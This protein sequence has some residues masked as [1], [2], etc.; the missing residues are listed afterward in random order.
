MIRLISN[1]VPSNQMAGGK[2]SASEGAWKPPP[3]VVFRGE[4]QDRRK[5]GQ[6]GLLVVVCAGVP[7]QCGHEH[8]AGPSWMAKA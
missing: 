6:G 7:H 3:L 8:G 4:R 2:K 1:G 5:A